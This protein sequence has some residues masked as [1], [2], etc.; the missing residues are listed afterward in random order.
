MCV[1]LVAINRHLANLFKPKISLSYHHF[2]Y[3]GEHMR[4]SK[5]ETKEITD[6]VWVL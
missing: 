2:F 1:N 4:Q 5:G 3:F 6:I